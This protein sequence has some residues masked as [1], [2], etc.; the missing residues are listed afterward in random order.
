MLND[1]NDAV[2]AVTSGILFLIRLEFVIVLD[3][4]RSVYRI[5]GPLTFDAIVLN[6]QLRGE[7]KTR[8]KCEWTNPKMKLHL[9]RYLF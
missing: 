2:C 6:G 7:S 8:S 5:N 9:K 3:V 1:S 4:G